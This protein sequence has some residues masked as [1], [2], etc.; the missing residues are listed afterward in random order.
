MGGD[1]VSD[2]EARTGRLRGR[3]MA[4]EPSVCHERAALV[5]GVYERLGGSVPPILL[6]ARALAAVLGGMSIW[7]GPDER[8][9]GNQAG[10]PRSAPL[11]PEYSWEWILE[12][13]DTL[14]LR[15]ADRFAVPTETAAALR[16]ILP[17]WR[18]RSFREQAVQALPPEVLRAHHALLFLLTSLGCGVGHLAP[19]Y[20]TVLAIGLDGLAT[21]ARRQMALLD[22]TDPDC[23]RE[24][25]YCR[26]AIEVCQAAI[27]F[28]GRYADLAEAMAETE[29]DPARRAELSEI[30]RICR[31][32]PA[33]PAGSFPEAL[34]A[35]WF[36]HLIIQ[37]E[38]N[39]HSISPGRF[40]QYMA[41]FHDADRAAGRLGREGAQELLDELWI[42]FNDILKLRD[43]TASIGFGGYPLFQNLIVGGQMADGSDATHDLSYLC[44]EAT[45]RTRLPQPS[46][47]VRVH[48]GSPPAFLRAAAEVV[49][50]GLGL[51]AFFNDDAIVPVLQNMGVP[52]AE[53]RGY[54]EVGCVE[55]QV[56]GKTNGYYPAGFLNLGKLLSLALHDGT[57]PVSGERLG[58]ADPAFRGFAR[59][60]DVVAALDRQLEHA[61]RLI[62]A[63]DNILDE[64]HGRLAP[65]P[66]VS[67]FVDDCLAR[68]LAYE[69]GGAVYNYTGPNSVGLANVADALMAVKRLVFEE[70]RVEM[71]ALLT[72]L[73]EDF[74]GREPGRLLLLNR[75]PKYGNDDD[76]VDAITRELA[77]KIL[78]GFKQY[79]NPRGGRFEPGLQSISAHALFRDA[80]AATPD[81]RT[82]N[83]L[84]A[85]GGISPAQ[86][87]DRK[88]PTA[89][90]RSAA[91]LDH[92]EASNGTLLNLKLSPDS[93]AGEAGLGNLTALIRTY[94]QLGG[95]HVQF[96]VVDSALLREAQRHPERHRDLVVRV[97]GFSVLFTSIDPVLQEDIIERTEH[98]V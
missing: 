92:R 8:I 59:Y 31:K 49:R 85:D 15:T 40:D 90:I 34:Q 64:L 88:G 87:R 7:I 91:K 82:A 26:A 62:V 57:D 86:G 12:E 25:D 94:F 45:R 60:E 46:L 81:G 77:A 51:P 30:A 11:F 27:L 80:V 41:P 96:N 83:M 16:D 21:R 33:G 50:D 20:T 54:A 38:S 89:V 52:L 47:S 2:G 5:T 67:L 93:V 66:F 73:D 22:R 78:M 53:A 6:R 32:V 4:H 55:P 44:L 97:A 61:I 68:G 70:R 10:R 84:L 79:R 35:F 13:L 76:A 71:A 72:M 28:A 1:V 42:K 14:P 74:A 43:K 65:N 17:R 29:E 19:D 98:R 9:V 36:V 18:G 37:I 56:P 69:Q 75:A 39:G 58:P 95:Q 48:A 23:L 3:L 24:L 63:G